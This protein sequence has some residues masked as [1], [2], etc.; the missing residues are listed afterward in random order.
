M[1]NFDYIAKEDMKEHNPNQP[2]ISD[3]SYR[4]LLVGG[5]KS[6]KT[7][8]LLNLI[9]H[10]SDIDKIH[11]YVKDPCEAKYQLLVNK[12]KSI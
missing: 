4:I 1:F 3:H 2:E 8:A 5:S 11:L 9:N 6:R 7:S 12:R 10:E